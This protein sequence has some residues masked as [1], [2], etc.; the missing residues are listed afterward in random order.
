MPRGGQNPQG[1]CEPRAYPRVVGKGRSTLRHQADLTRNAVCTHCF[2][3][4]APQDAPLSRFSF[5]LIDAAH[6]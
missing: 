6:S 5:R 2:L 1:A 3:Q 4:T